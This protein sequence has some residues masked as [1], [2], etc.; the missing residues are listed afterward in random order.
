MIDREVNSWIKQVN[1]NSNRAGDT[2][3]RVRDYILKDIDPVSARMTENLE[4]AVRMKIARRGW[5]EELTGLWK[6]GDESSG[7]VEYHYTTE[8]PAKK[9]YGRYV[10]RLYERYY[11]GEM[12]NPEA[13]LTPE[14]KKIF[15]DWMERKTPPN[16]IS[17]KALFGNT[18]D[19]YT[20]EEWERRFGEDQNPGE[21]AAEAPQEDT[22]ELELNFD[23]IE[24]EKETVKGPEG[25]NQFTIA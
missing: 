25:I 12:E 13:V 6:E 24:P 10:G 2:A 9:D 23:V 21:S 7:D 17:T 11:N 1:R 5:D 16:E 4:F 8:V 20:A 18:R 3:V 22:Q 14:M 19:A 15:D